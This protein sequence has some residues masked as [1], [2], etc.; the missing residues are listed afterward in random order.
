ML[1]VME[2]YGLGLVISWQG[3]VLDRQAGSFRDAKLG[4]RLVHF[5]AVM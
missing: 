3:E 1:L 4:L 5:I 2:Q